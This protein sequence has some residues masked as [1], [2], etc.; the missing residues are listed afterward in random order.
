MIGIRLLLVLVALYSGFILHQMWRG[1]GPRDVEMAAPGHWTVLGDDLI[2]A[3][4]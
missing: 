3:Y 2:Y 1:V 4:D